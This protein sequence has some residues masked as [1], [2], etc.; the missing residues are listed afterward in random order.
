MYNIKFTRLSCNAVFTISLLQTSRTFVVF[1]D[2][3]SWMSSSLLYN[4]LNSLY[5]L[6]M[7][8]FTAAGV[9]Y[10]FLH[11][12]YLFSFFLWVQGVGL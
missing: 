7:V 2:M 5:I 6:D 10:V 8:I 1:V 3:L 11:V 4:N 12:F 9:L